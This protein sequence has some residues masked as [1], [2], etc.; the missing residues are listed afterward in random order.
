MAIYLTPKAKRNEFG[1]LYTDT[2]GKT[3]LRAFITAVPEKGKANLELIKMIS[4]EMK[5]PKSSI[6][7]I[8]GHTSH[9]KILEITNSQIDETWIRNLNFI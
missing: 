6:G 4:K 3:Y 7:I 1:E 9:R 2:D 5:I 8:A